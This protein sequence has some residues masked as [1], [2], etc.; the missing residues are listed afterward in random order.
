MG[1]KDD[2]EQED[3]NEK[4]GSEESRFLKESF[5]QHDND[6]DIKK[7]KGAIVL[8]EIKPFFKCTHLVWSFPWALRPKWPS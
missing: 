3:E 1:E 8:S 6:D 5:A 7:R 4:N 2:D